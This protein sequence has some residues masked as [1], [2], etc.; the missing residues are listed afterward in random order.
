MA[1]TLDFNTAQRP[2]LELTMMDDARTVLRVKTP[3]EGMIQELQALAPELKKVETGDRDAVDMIYDLGARLMSCN[4]DFI[5]V[6]AADL[7]EKY[8]LDLES[9]LV[10]FSA[11]VDFI[12]ALSNEKN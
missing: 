10:F 7:R 3:T 2:T 1:R 8:R 11:Y 6:T 12:N 9:M 4:R 5:T